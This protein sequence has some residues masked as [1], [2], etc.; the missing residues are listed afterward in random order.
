ML[1]VSRVSGSPSNKVLLPPFPSSSVLLLLLSSCIVL[2]F[3]IQQERDPHAPDDGVIVL[4]CFSG[5]ES[6]LIMSQADKTKVSVSASCNSTRHVSGEP[7]SQAV[8]LRSALHHR[9]IFILKSNIIVNVKAPS[10][11]SCWVRSDGQSERVWLDPDLSEQAVGVGRFCV[12]VGV[13]NRTLPPLHLGDFSPFV[14]SSMRTTKKKT[15]WL[16]L[17]ALICYKMAAISR[18]GLDTPPVFWNPFSFVM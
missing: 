18:S 15:P 14:R 4:V 10:L 6:R 17:S 7:Y 1:L 5:F 3:L 12:N 16:F 11:S 13:S 9:F 8:C 2:C